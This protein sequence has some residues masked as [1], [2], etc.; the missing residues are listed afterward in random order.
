MENNSN[1][2]PALNTI[3]YPQ[4]GEQ[5]YKFNYNSIYSRRVMRCND[6]QSDQ[7]ILN[8]Y[9]FQ[10]LK[11]KKFNE[12]S[13]SKKLSVCFSPPPI[14]LGKRKTTPKR[15]MLK[16]K[17]EEN[18]DKVNS[19]YERK[20]KEQESEDEEEEQK[21]PIVFKFKRD[22][23]ELNQEDY[24]HHNEG[25]KRNTIQTTNP[26]QSSYNYELEQMNDLNKVKY[27]EIQLDNEKNYSGLLCYSSKCFSSNTKNRVNNCSII[28][29]KVKFKYL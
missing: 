20:K 11:V 12:K 14:I 24:D 10:D 2:F 5:K 28:S 8:K 25:G 22:F 17:S 15:L 27:K 18:I 1:E 21:H 29:K 7:N 23:E 13:N 6:I 16:P 4:S 9:T 19:D 26:I 3:S